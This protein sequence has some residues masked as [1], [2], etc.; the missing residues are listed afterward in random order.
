MRKIHDDTHHY[1][2]SW[3]D[4]GCCRIEIYEPEAGEA[5]RRPVIV[6]AERDDNAGPL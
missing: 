2:G 5:D 6:A 3:R 1:Q 4:G